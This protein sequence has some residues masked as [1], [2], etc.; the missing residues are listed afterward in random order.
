M[1]LQRSYGSISQEKPSRMTLKTQFPSRDAPE[2]GAFAGTFRFRNNHL[3]VCRGKCT[4]VPGRL[5]DI[6][7]AV[8][9]HTP[10]MYVYLV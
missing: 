4:F 7:A 6:L 8:V 5:L 9:D 3:S 10:D 1:D 2:N